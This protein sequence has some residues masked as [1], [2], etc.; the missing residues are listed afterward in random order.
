MSSI[1]YYTITSCCEQEVNTG[2]FNIPGS[3]VT[4]P[5]VYTYTGLTFIEPT[6]GRKKSVFNHN[7]YN[8]LL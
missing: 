6:T 4:G 1:P 8:S 3:Y 5:N 2:T 7:S